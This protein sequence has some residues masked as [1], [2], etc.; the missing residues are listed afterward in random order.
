MLFDSLAVVAN[1]RRLLGEPCLR[2]YVS[3]ILDQRGSFSD[4]QDLEA[5]IMEVRPARASF[6]TSD[7]DPFLLTVQLFTFTEVS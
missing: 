6:A 1:H 5:V 7:G 4:G 3:P 2:A